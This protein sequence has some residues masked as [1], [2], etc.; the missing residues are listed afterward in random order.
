MLNLT[1]SLFVSLALALAVTSTPAYAQ[2]MPAATA[3]S[4]DRMATIAAA[5]V[6]RVG[7]TGDYVPYSLLNATGQYE[8]LD[9]EMA[10]ALATALGVRL[11]IVKT[12][13][14]AMTADL[15]ADKFDLAM[16]GVSDS[17]ERAKNGLL[18]HVYLLD[19]K[20]ALVRASD[21]AKYKA[22]ADLDKPEVR[23]AVNPGGTN[24]KFVD[25]SLTHATV[26]VVD[27]NLKIPDL[28]A[29]GDAD[30]MVTDGVEAALAVKRDSRLAVADPEHPF[31]TVKKVYY[32]HAGD[33]A[34]EAFVD[35]F[36]D[37]ALADGTFAKLRA[38]WIG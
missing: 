36:L 26:K 35:R 10:Q 33:A 21:R 6:L 16:G 15:L 19:G 5:G 9:V 18:S 22:I 32:L 1:R 38:K 7:L 13:W 3:A 2:S 29:S 23:V 17:P 11:Q 14:P 8:G 24:Q 31:T 37:R 25:A 27:Q 34:F 30:V 28:V 4:A 12:S 20:V